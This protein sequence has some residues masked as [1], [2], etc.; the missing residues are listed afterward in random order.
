[1]E[2]K[3]SIWNYFIQMKSWKHKIFKEKNRHLGGKKI[4]GRLEGWQNWKAP[5]AEPRET[6][7]RMA[8]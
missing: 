8:G 5:V 2:L 7:A 1:M 4:K 6:Q 3:G